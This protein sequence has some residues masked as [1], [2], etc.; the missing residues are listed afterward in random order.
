[1]YF[2]ILCYQRDQG[3]FLVAVVVEE[4]QL[5]PLWVVPKLGLLIPQVEV[6][7]SFL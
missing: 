7:V 3:A 2:Q 6:E 4:M 5:L 1:V